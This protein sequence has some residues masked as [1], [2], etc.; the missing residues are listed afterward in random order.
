MGS[1][2]SSQ[3]SSQEDYGADLIESSSQIYNEACKFQQNES[4]IEG[5]PINSCN[6]IEII[7]K[8]KF[9]L[10]KIILPQNKIGSGFLVK[11]DEGPRVCGLMTNNHVIDR[12][13]DDSATKGITLC[14]EYCDLQFEIKK[15][16]VA[17]FFTS[18]LLDVTF[19]KFRPNVEQRLV[20]RNAKFLS[21]VK[22]LPDVNSVV[23]IVQHPGGKKAS[24]SSGYLLSYRQFN[25][26]HRASTIPGSSGSPVMIVEKGESRVIGVHK[27]GIEG[28]HN[29]ASNIHEV[30]NAILKDLNGKATGKRRVVITFYDK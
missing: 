1:Y 17:Y 25:V 12:I 27:K 2:E 3:S 21:I 5:N 14:F 11:L 7:M 22:D 20:Q 30:V 4:L 28:K 18:E 24:I 9:S 29:I 15:T 10:C 6:D 8:S 23:F 13:P 16:D 26:Y 19:L